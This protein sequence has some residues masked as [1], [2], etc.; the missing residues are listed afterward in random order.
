[1]F[2]NN[3]RYR[4]SRYGTEIPDEFDERLSDGTV[5]HKKVVFFK[6]K[7]VTDSE[8]GAQR[9]VMD[10]DQRKQALAGE[11]AVL[12]RDAKPYTDPES[13]EPRG[14]LVRNQPA[15]PQIAVSELNKADQ[16]DRE[17]QAARK[18]K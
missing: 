9:E 13:G 15:S 6:P 4:R 5:F 3:A 10:P 11:L 7:T 8:T 1:M 2:L 14:T 16:K 18:S 17:E 12:P